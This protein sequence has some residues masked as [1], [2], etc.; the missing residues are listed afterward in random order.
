MVSANKN[1][2]MST[3]KERFRQDCDILLLEEVQFLSGKE[4]IQAEVCYTLD[5]LM[6]R[7]NRLVF[8][9]CYLPGDIGHLSQ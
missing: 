1:G 2:R 8:T 6:G 9:C 5:T 7:N 3:F 4:K